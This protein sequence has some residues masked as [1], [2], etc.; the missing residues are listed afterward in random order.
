MIE[1][2]LK[3]KKKTGTNKKEEERKEKENE[4]LLEIGTKN[5]IEK[6]TKRGIIS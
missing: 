2:C 3:R 1:K 6:C 4:S 5:W